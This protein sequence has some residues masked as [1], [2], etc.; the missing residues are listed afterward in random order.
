M[1]KRPIALITGAGRKINIGSEIARSLAG[2][3]WDICLTYWNA[4]DKSMPWGSQSE[5]IRELTEE[6]I[7]KGARVW[8][9]ELDLSLSESPGVLFSDCCKKL[10]NPT[11]LILSHC[12]SVD[13]D[14]RTTTLESF[15]RHF[16]L[17]AR[18]V[19]LLIKEFE[20]QFEPGR[21]R[22]RIIALTSDHTA[23]NLP[24]GASK[25]AL[26]R[27]V[28]AAAVEFRDRNIRA[29]VINP[30]ANDTG[31]MDENLKKEVRKDTLAGRLGCPKDTAN[32]VS[33]LCS[34]EG[35]WINGQLLHS[36][37]GLL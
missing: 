2:S 4:Y 16:A 28:L 7:N 6:L 33:F 35:E 11:A 15:D 37:G 19:W 34:E 13:S 23:G 22:G 12:Y 8:A 18:A 27:I 10:G 29:N 25:G 9:V 32:L 26:D 1:T 5:D 20:K 31:W 30:G 36:N 14:I 17:N 3:G 21:G 24:Y